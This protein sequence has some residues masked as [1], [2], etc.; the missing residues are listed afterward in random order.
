MTFI[1]KTKIGKH[2]YLYLV[3]NKWV[4]GKVKQKYLG[5]LGREDAL[6]K[7]LEN[8]LQL[9]K[10]ND[11]ELENVLYQTPVALWSLM[12]EM[13]LHSIF[14]KHFSKKWGVDAATAACV[15]I[16]NYATDKRT[17]NTLSEWY[18]QTW[19]P[20]LLGIPADKMNKDL[21]CRTM[22]F[23]SEEKI[24]AIHA[25]VYK[26]AKEKFKLSDN[27]L[28]YDVTAITFEGGECPLAKHGYNSKHA[29][30][31]QVNLAMSVTLERFPA[32]HKVFE[33]NT[34]D[35]KTL[36]KSIELVEKAGVLQKTVFIFD[37]GI[38]SNDNFNAI[39]AKGAEFICGFTKNARV[40]SLI[41][42]L[43]PRDFARIDDDVSFHE[44]VDG[45]RRLIFFSSKKLREDQRV[46]REERLK[47]ISEK[48]AG[49]A[50]T[51]SRYDRLRLHEKIGAVCG[52]YRK[53][54]EI[55]TEQ[56]FS[57]SV[58]QDVL[59]KAVAVEG[60]YAI[61]TNTSLDPGNVLSRYRDRNFIEM[62]FKDLKMFVDLRPVRH[63]KEN[64][65]LAH[66]FFAVLAFGMRSLA[67]LKLRRAGLQMT[68][69]EAISRLNKV[70]ALVVNGKLLRLT[71]VTEDTRKIAAAIAKTA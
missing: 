32:S 71:G 1:R 47:K 33:G 70:R 16:L 43:A 64:R 27:L 18:A 8:C 41:A 50:K 3:T 4:N 21:L 2:T 24:E 31:P 44:T 34:K 62:S 60:K 40:K 19:L 48:L 46:F 37:R 61:L 23:F 10:I 6:P 68:A 11:A 57:F 63:W 66:V 20:H 53:F 7:L 51:A 17:K 5:Y 59:D 54:F 58:K 29:Y 14:A 65:V 55:E 22:D 36:Q 49:L 35:C 15:M 69:E 30:A 38:C 12:E 67:Q 26:I 42:A 52:S 13:E 28:L 45:K 56:V 9:K 39:E 25:E